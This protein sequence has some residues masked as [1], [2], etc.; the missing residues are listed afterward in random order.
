MPKNM[1]QETRFR[2]TFSAEKSGTNK[3]GAFKNVR[4]TAETPIKKT[5]KSVDRLP[6][7][8]AENM[9]IKR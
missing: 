1:I 7:K 8:R 9:R 4:R 3:P 2:D 6:R 5:K